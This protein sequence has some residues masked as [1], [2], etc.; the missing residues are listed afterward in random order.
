M[1]PLFEGS[2]IWQRRFTVYMNVAWVSQKVPC[3]MHFPGSFD[4][5]SACPGSRDDH[6]VDIGGPPS[7]DA[8][9]RL[10]HPSNVTFKWEGPMLFSGRVSKTLG[11]P[12][13][14][15]NTN[16]GYGLISDIRQMIAKSMYW[17][18]CYYNKQVSHQKH[19]ELGHLSK[20]RAISVPGNHTRYCCQPYI[21]SFSS[22]DPPISPF[23]GTSMNSKW[24][25]EKNSYY[26]TINIRSRKACPFP[27]AFTVGTSEYWLFV[28]QVS[29]KRLVINPIYAPMP[30]Y[31]P[32]RKLEENLIMWTLPTLTRLVLVVHGKDWCYNPRKFDYP[33]HS[34]SKSQSDCNE[35]LVVLTTYILFKSKQH[36]MRVV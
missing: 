26:A 7:L 36:Q 31:E 14:F 21:H 13:Q 19:E 20:S 16:Q 9:G 1:T 25:N 30:K 10:L 33:G 11:W 2:T 4:K 27:S 15:L 23:S 24:L 8:P 28:L 18:E 17:D 6:I 22:W 35:V 32:R 29:H 3:E 12:P 5:L 34:P